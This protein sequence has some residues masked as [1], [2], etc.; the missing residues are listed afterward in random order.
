VRGTHELSSHSSTVALEPREAY[1]AFAPSY[2][3]WHW[4]R[5]WRGNERPLVE[6]WLASL[7][8]GLVL[9]AGSGTGPYSSLIRQAGHRSV[10]VDLTFEMLELEH[11]A[12]DAAHCPRTASRVQGDIRLLPF[13][14]ATFDHLLCT[15]VLTHVAL[16]PQA[17][18]EFARILRP[19][20]SLLISDV[21]PDHSYQHTS[22]R[23]LPD[24]ERFAV[25]TYKHSI[26]DFK[27]AVSSAGL[28]LL[29]IRE[30]L[31][32]SLTWKPPRLGFEKV[33]ADR[34]RPIFFIS[35]LTRP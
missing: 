35:H 25:E 22:M 26:A 13:K 34:D 7:R 33:H 10:S 27:Q 28:R 2:D 29:D 4:S 3:H 30:Y 12:D 21:H 14:E 8:P 17:L 15:R 24:G 11:V 23:L 6:R 31:F 16:L 9:D 19:G 32:A 20:A 5:F 1:R 18:L